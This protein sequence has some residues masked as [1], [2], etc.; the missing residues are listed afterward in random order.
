MEKRIEL[1]S[2]VSA[3]SWEE[4]P[5][6]R[7]ALDPKNKEIIFIQIDPGK[8]TGIGVELKKGLRDHSRVEHI[9]V[10]GYFDGHQD[11]NAILVYKTLS[12]SG[13]L[14]T[15]VFGAGE[16]FF[17]VEPSGRGR[18]HILEN[19]TNMAVVLLIRT[20]RELTSLK[21]A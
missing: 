11:G 16:D 19:H 15:K 17:S 9:E 8:N 6:G 18:L 13:R 5:Y 20:G 21:R 12:Q 1:K 4:A 7:K 2:L 3:L 10:L 14:I